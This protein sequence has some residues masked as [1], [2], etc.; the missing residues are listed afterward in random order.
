MILRLESRDLGWSATTDA[1][2]LSVDAG[3]KDRS[4]VASRERGDVASCRKPRGRTYEHM[5]VTSR[6]DRRGPLLAQH[7]LELAQALHHD[8]PPDLP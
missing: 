8:L 2:N 5:R 1:H 4:L 7:P 3:R 6:D